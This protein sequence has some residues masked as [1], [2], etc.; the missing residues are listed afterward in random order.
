MID[1][2]NAGHIRKVLQDAIEAL[3]RNA[4]A[5]PHTVTAPDG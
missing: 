5:K 1:A 2:S 4:A 3:D